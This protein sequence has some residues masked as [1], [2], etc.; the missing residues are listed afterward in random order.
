MDFVLVIVPEIPQTKLYDLCGSTLNLIFDLSVPHTSTV[1]QPLLN[2]S[3]I[4]N[5]CVPLH[6]LK[7]QINK[8]FTCDIGKVLNTDTKD[9][10]YCRK[11]KYIL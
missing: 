1:I 11:Y 6:A 7:S 3:S 4:G 5:Q 10:P 9:V 2:I 8:G